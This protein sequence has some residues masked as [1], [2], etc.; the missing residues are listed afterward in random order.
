M[1]FGL[2]L[3]L[4]K[5][6]SLSDITNMFTFGVWVQYFPSLLQIRVCNSDYCANIKAVYNK[7]RLNN[8]VN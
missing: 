5:E 4:H 8:N 6:H 3:F 7:N 1:L 2:E